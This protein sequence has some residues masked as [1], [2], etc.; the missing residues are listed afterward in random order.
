VKVD[1]ETQPAGLRLDDGLR[2]S[3][4]N[5]SGTTYYLYNGTTPVC[6]PSSTGTVTATNVF[7]AD[8]LLS[9]TVTPSS[10]STTFYTFDAQG[11]VAQRLTSA[12]A[13]ASTD[14][15]DAW[16][17]RTSTASTIPDPFGYDAQWGYYTDA[18]T[19]LILCTHRYYDPAAGRSVSPWSYL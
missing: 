10:P 1:V 16:G 4:A 18:E 11:N 19:G 2:A 5:A 13:V 14:R 12:D 8:G 7:G 17:G 9:R 6:E 3:K 15:Y